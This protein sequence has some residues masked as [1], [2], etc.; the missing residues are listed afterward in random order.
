MRS[1]EYSAGIESGKN[2]E[3]S[4]QEVIVSSFQEAVSSST[5]RYYIEKE[6]DNSLALVDIDGCLIEDDRIK[7]PFFSHRY[8]PV[9][10]DENKES[11]LDLV[12]AF[13]GSVAVITNRGTKD[14]IVWNT[15]K[16]F[17]K[18]KNFLRS[19][20]LNLEVYK[21]LLRQFPYIKRGDTENV[22]DY[23]GQRVNK[24]NKGVLDIY[25]IEDWSIAS[26]NRGTFYR[27]VSKEIE[28]RYGGVLRVKNFVVKR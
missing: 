21:S 15:G 19:E 24:S 6:H 28:N 25:S 12:T 16:V 23:L 22:I 8:E 10:S 27:F 26:L 5:E 9:I 11:F 4:Y 3:S 1:P 14:N 20:E 18:V 2:V 13:N 17:S 7:L